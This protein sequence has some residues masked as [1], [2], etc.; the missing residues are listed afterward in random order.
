MGGF[1]RCLFV[2]VYRLTKTKIELVKARNVSEE[3]ASN[4]IQNIS[5]A[6]GFA[7]IRF[8]KVYFFLIFNF[9]PDGSFSYLGLTMF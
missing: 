2:Y 6:K 9:S 4:R 5:N 1:S 7:L 3:T 8:K